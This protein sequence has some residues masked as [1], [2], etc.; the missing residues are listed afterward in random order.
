[1]SKGFIDVVKQLATDEDFRARFLADPR[2]H[3]LEMGFP[4]EMVERAVPAL[5][6]A[7]VAGGIVGGEVEPF[8]SPMFGW[9]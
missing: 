6:A 3:L 9:R 2:K 8:I 7:I 5:M 1:M 4:L